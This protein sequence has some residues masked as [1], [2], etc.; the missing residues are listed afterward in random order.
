MSMYV[1]VNTEIPIYGP[2]EINIA[3]NLNNIDRYF[4]RSNTSTINYTFTNSYVKMVNNTSGTKTFTLTCLYNISNVSFEYRM[5]STSYPC[6][7][8]VNDVLR[9]S[10]STS[11][12]ARTLSI[13]NLSKGDI[14]KI[15]LG[16]YRTSTS[17]YQPYASIKCDNI[18]TIEDVIVSYENKSLAKKITK[19][20]ISKYETVPIY[21]SIPT[22]LTLHN[23]FNQIFSTTTA[24]DASWY[25]AHHN[26]TN[27]YYVSPDAL[28]DESDDLVT[29][30][31]LTALVNI[32]ELTI[33]WDTRLDRNYINLKVN[34]QIILNNARDRQS[35]SWSGA[36]N[37]GDTI[38]MKY[39]RYYISDDDWTVYLESDPIIKADI[40]YVDILNI[41]K[42]KKAYIGDS[43]N[44]AKQILG[45]SSLNQLNPV[46]SLGTRV[47]CAQNFNNKYAL[48]ADTYYGALY[49]FDKTL[50]QIST[51]V[52]LG[53]GYDYGAMASTTDYIIISRGY[54][55]IKVLNQSFTQQSHSLTFGSREFS[56]GTSFNNHAI[57]AGGKDENNNSINSI[58]AI[59]NSL[60]QTNLTNLSEARYDLSSSSIP[61][62]Y[63]LI[64]G[65]YTQSS[66]V[67]C[68]DNLFTKIT[69]ISKLLRPAR[70]TKM[71]TQLNDYVLF[72]G[73][74]WS[75]KIYGTLY[76]KELACSMLPNTGTGSVVMAASVEGYIINYSSDT[77]ISFNDSFTRNVVAHPY[78]RYYGAATNIG[79]Y[80]LVGGGYD[81]NDA[82]VPTEVFQSK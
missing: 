45:V 42:I 19:G 81:D 25:L 3:W 72:L 48:F 59:N 31:T 20:Y 64:G 58:T 27:R 8:Y 26:Y 28:S 13:G 39:T 11:S 54:N 5:R 57:L 78:K 15:Q 56:T 18:N 60:T 82:S 52:S 6:Y 23:D 36:L 66:V 4:T 69:G 17:T 55:A 21:N 68:Y 65:G 73:N 32:P 44:I 79:N 49:A 30:V 14:I 1:G 77:T 43:N 63:L 2:Q 7:I 74:Q 75:G 35:G 67:D 12:S 70:G 71:A 10:S 16:Y 51:G 37:I 41:K 80:L 53:S 46:Q 40:D 34:E 29:S 62:K 61:N 22:T 76:T 33:T 47:W 38:F 24:G 9:S 50:T